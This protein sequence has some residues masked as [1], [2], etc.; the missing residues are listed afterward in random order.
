MSDN[1]SMSAEHLT[2]ESLSQL[3]RTQKKLEGGQ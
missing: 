1:A 3:A 2:F